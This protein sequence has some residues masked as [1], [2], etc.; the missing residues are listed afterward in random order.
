MKIEVKHPNYGKFLSNTALIEQQLTK[1]N[2]IV[3]EVED[4]VEQLSRLYDAI[5]DNPEK[6]WLP[7]AATP[8]SFKAVQIAT[9]DNCGKPWGSDKSAG[10]CPGPTKCSLPLDQARVARN[11]AAREENKKTL[12]GVKRSNRTNWGKSSGKSN[13]GGSSDKSPTP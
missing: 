8:S 2:E 10:Q 3:A 12:D 11:K 9:C 1:G 6:S 4:I 5:I 13:Q 7:K